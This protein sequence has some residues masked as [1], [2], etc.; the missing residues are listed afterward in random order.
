MIGSH[1]WPSFNVKLLKCSGQSGEIMLANQKNE[2]KGTA[3]PPPA[4]KPLHNLHCHTLLLLFRKYWSAVFVELLCTPVWACSTESRH[5]PDI[6]ATHPASSTPGQLAK[7]DLARASGLIDRARERYA[8]HVSLNCLNSLLRVVSEEYRR[9]GDVRLYLCPLLCLRNVASVPEAHAGV[10]L[11]L[12]QRF[13]RGRYARCM[14]CPVEA[15]NSLAV[16]LCLG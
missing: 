8:H 5:R 4:L 10:Y 6:A 13:D 2:G 9:A 1:S 12:C 11:W 15:W 16:F 14:S 3:E 7:L